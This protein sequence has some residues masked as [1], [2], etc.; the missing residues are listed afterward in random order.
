MPFSQ[1]I[2]LQRAITDRKSIVSFYESFGSYNL[3][4]SQETVLLYNSDNKADFR[5]A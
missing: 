1:Y 2:S 3:Q 4:K 5:M